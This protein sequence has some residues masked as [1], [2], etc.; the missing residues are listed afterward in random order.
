MKW[1][2]NFGTGWGFIADGD[3]VSFID[4]HGILLEDISIIS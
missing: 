3:S 4:N 1:L 2:S